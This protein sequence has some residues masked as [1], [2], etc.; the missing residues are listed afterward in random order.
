MHDSDVPPPLPLARAQIHHDRLHK[1]LMQQRAM[2]QG[3]ESALQEATDLANFMQDPANARTTN[4]AFITDSTR[5]PA[6]HNRL[7]KHYGITMLPNRR[8]VLLVGDV[9]PVKNVLDTGAKET[10]IGANLTKLLRLSPA[11]LQPGAPYITA[12]GKIELSLGSTKGKNPITIG[13]GTVHPCTVHLHVHLSLSKEFDIIV[14]NSFIFP[15]G[16][17]PHSWTEIY[18]YRS[19]F[20]T[21][22]HCLAG[23]PI[24]IHETHDTPGI[25]MARKNVIYRHRAI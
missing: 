20:R 10:M 25:Y 21:E 6:H 13:E 24:A 15:M 23:V 19:D 12:L 4:L 22:G 3:T 5:L 11:D 7:A 16:G 14:G 2:V 18:M 9:K 1:I 17:Y 8:G